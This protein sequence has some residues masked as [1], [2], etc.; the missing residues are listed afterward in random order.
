[1]AN[2]TQ[3]RRHSGRRRSRLTRG[4]KALAA[5]A[6]AA[7]KSMFVRPDVELPT[8]EGSEPGTPDWGDGIQPAAGGERKSDAWYTFLILGRDTGGGGNTDTMLLAS[9][10]VT[11][12]RRQS[13]PSPGIPW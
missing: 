9:Y 8:G 1:M 12:Q 7:W 6:A 2:E 10:D 11:N 5:V 4:Q 13:C 3:K